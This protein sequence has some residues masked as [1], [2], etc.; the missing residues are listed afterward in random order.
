MTNNNSISIAESIN[1]RLYKSLD[2]YLEDIGMIFLLTVEDHKG[3][4]R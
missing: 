3:Q 1:K 4:V 2:K